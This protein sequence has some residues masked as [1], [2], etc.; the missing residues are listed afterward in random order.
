MARYLVLLLQIALRLSLVRAQMPYD[1][2]VRT[3]GGKKEFDNALKEISDYAMS[4]RGGIKN[5][6]ARTPPS[7]GA[8]GYVTK[9][10]FE[11]GI[12]WAV[13]LSESTKLEPMLSGIAAAR[14]VEKYCPQIPVA[15]FHGEAQNYRDSKVAFCLM[16]WVDAVHLECE[17]KPHSV[18][19]WVT[20]MPK[21]TVT[22]LAEFIYNL[23]TCP[24][25]S[26][27]SK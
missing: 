1:R 25:P 14:A 21:N 13:K 27:E 9:L 6:Y 24:V 16:D 11:D 5:K 22:Q 4:L 18:Y 15:R 10:T 12:S 23:T 17:F 19:G 20:V 8:W 3:M 2:L 7:Q 26:S